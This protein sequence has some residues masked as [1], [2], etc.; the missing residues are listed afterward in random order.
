[1]RALTSLIVELLS[2]KA[3]DELDDLPVTLGELAAQHGQ[4]SCPLPGCLACIEAV[5]VVRPGYER[6]GV[7]VDE[8]AAQCLKGLPVPG[9][10][11]SD[12]LLHGP[13]ADDARRVDA[14]VRDVGNRAL[15]LLP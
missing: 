15:K 1:M 11:V 10:H 4:V 2:R 9:R 3:G 5:D 6:F 14:I 13:G 8:I 12:Q 7:A